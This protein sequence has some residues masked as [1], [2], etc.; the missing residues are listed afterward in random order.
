M[1]EIRLATNHYKRIIIAAILFVAL[2]GVIK[3]CTNA[4]FAAD[5]Q[6]NAGERVFTIHDGDSQTGLITSA[7][8]LR[9]V[10]RQARITV[11]QN[12]ITE[13]SLDEPLVASSYEANIYRARPVVIKDGA[14]SVRIVTAY[15][16]AR[17]ITKQAGI[18]L[19]DADTA[20]LKPVVDIDTYGVSEVLAIDRATPITFV[21]Y[22]KKLQTSTRATTVEA[23]LAE[24]KIAMSKDDTVKPG[25]A[26]PITAGMTIE[27]WRNGKQMVTIDEDI[28]FTARQVRD[29]NRERG[30]KEVQTK[31]ETGKRT[32]TYE[33]EVRDGK[34]VARKETNSITTKQPVEQVEII[35]VKGMY[36]TPSENESITWDY[37]VSKGL[38][39][40]QTAGVMGN[41]QQEHGFQTSGD[42]LAQW[43]GSRKARL[44]SMYPDTYMTIQSQLDYLWYELSGPY[45]KVLATI[46]AQTTVDGAVTVFQNQYERCSVCVESRR[47]QYAYNILASH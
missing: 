15:R 6:V 47:I 22:G 30:Y 13:P 40:E 5:A 11:N 10:L 26:T 37:L 39:R 43:T 4:A 28:A 45:A 32:V 18:V 14:K 31:G 24:R 12:D 17:Q 25:L 16:T 2:A 34:E 23:L 8:T 33:I 41:L 46:K 42:G 36:T 20:E 44:Q 38:T 29:V 27:L 1:I 3:V 9:E 19:N 21:F 35:G 7:V